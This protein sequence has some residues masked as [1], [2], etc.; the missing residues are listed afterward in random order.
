VVELFASNFGDPTPLVGVAHGGS[1][2]AVRER[3]A[4]LAGVGPLQKAH[5]TLPIGRV[6][7]RLIPSFPNIPK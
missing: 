2:A 7:H 4:E 6:P 5:E 3:G 1:V